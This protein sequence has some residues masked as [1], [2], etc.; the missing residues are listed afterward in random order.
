MGNHPM[1]QPI[2]PRRFQQREIASHAGVSPS[3][4]S[5]VFNNVA[6]VSPELQRRVL[7]AAAELGYQEHT[8]PL[9]IQH[10][11][12]FVSLA[13]VN[14]SFDQFHADVAGGIEKECRRVGI[15]LS[16]I[17]VER[18][19]A[20]IDSYRQKIVQNDMDA[21]LFLSFDEHGMI[22]QL[23]EEGF[24]TVL[25]NIDEPTLRIDT[26]LPD[27]YNGPLHAVRHLVEHQ[28]RAILYATHLVRST[29]RR[30][31]AGYRAALEHDGIEFDPRLLLDVPLNT[32]DAYET[33]KAFLAHNPPHF[34]AVFCANDSTAIGVLHALQEA[35]FDVP[36]DVSII[37]YDDWPITASITP[38]LTTVRIEREE[39]GMIAMQRLLERVRNPAL[40]P[41]RIEIATQLIE[42]QSVARAPLPS[43]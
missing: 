27:N 33:M 40:T 26:V 11:G 41:V 23:Q 25:V 36:G 7:A 19:P 3:T 1:T 2:L 5:R 18:Q 24:P 13:T 37:G 34:T 15:H 22:E 10:V 14:H 42:R 8:T 12:L 43:R 28:H 29:I 39:M 4:V 6:G 30:R 20:N 16:Y 9:Y 17:L 35:G 21:L 31:F 38:P 32:E